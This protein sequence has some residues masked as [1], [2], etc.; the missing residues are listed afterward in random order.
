MQKDTT[1]MDGNEDTLKATMGDK[2]LSL[3]TKWVSN[4]NAVIAVLLLIQTSV[5]LYFA[6]TAFTFWI[7]DSITKIQTGAATISK[8]EHQLFRDELN[9]DREYQRQLFD[10]IGIKLRTVPLPKVDTNSQLKENS[11]GQ[12]K[13]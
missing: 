12:S 13:S 6:F 5:G 3:P 7:P 8:A 1:M 2:S 9:N 10:Q 4:A 11:D